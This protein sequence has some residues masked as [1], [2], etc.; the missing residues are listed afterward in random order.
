[1][2]NLEESLKK[3]LSRILKT[4]KKNEMPADK[5]RDAV[6]KVIEIFAM[7]GVEQD[8]NDKKLIAEILNVK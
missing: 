8:N 6:N 7:L 3:D 5:K 2:Q 4:I 1:M